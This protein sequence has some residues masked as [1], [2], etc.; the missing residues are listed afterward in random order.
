MQ[1]PN[2]LFIAIDDMRPF[3]GCYGDT[4]AVTPNIDALSARGVR[5]ENAMC[6]APSCGPSR[7]AIF[8]GRLSTTTGIYGFQDWV[9]REIFRDVVTMPEYFRRNGYTTY[10]SG[11]L[12]HNSTNT[13]AKT[14]V[15][16]ERNLER[17][18]PSIFTMVPRADRE[19]DETNLEA[20]L[21]SPYNHAPVRDECINWSGAENPE[22]DKHLSGPSDNP[23]MQCQDGETVKYA[24]RKLTEEHEKPFFLGAGFVRPHLPFI[25]P[26][27]YFQ[28][29]P[30]DELELH[31]VKNDDLVD[32]P[33]AARSNARIQD[34][35][36]IR[37]HERGRRR[38]IQAYYACCS[39]VD[40]MVG[41]VVKALDES[42]YRDNTIII[43]WSDHGW[44]LGEKRSWRKF[45]LWEESARTPMI[46]VDPRKSN[47][48]GSEC[49]RPVSLLDIFP[50]LAELCGLN[51]PDWCDG[52]SMV[53]LLDAPG[54]E[55][56]YPALTIQGKGNYSVRDE[57]WRYT[58]YFDGSEELYN[59][60]NDPYEWH[61]LAGDIQYTAEKK[62]LAAHLPTEAAPTVLPRGL[63]NWQDEEKNDMEGFK[64]QWEKWMQEC[65]PPLL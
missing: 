42:N 7:A 60:R 17:Q 43:L 33:W 31:P 19:W 8:T 4:N 20:I 35:I 15:A 9:G 45:S 59:H 3:L 65:D 40:D 47:T 23:V 49:I 54:R 10:T 13:Y 55:W 37:A 11:K 38:V 32:K 22:S 58:R 39:F 12:H 29:Y 50:T 61:N 52:R 48:A 44:H 27:E 63:S 30:L 2:I 16:V 62:R 34:D 57:Q 64:R 46:I 28:H 26:R 53:P 24:E 1:K 51:V 21:G 41:Q 18:E 5:F 14:R 36:Y 56:P 6:P 25:A